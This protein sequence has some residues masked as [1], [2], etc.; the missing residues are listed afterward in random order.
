[1]SVYSEKSRDFDIKQTW[2]LN[3]RTYDLIVVRL[4]P[5]IYGKRF[6]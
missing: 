3:T 2:N 5:I 6:K 1:M 4:T